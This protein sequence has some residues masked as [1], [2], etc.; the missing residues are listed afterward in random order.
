MTS[1][2]LL[3]LLKQNDLQSLQQ[4]SFKESYIFQL[5]IITVIFAGV[6]LAE[7]FMGL[8]KNNF[9]IIFDSLHNALHLVPLVFGLV[10]TY[11]ARK[12][13]DL[14]FSY[15]YSRL[16]IISSF[17]NCCFLIFFAV[18]LAFNAAHKI[19]ESFSEEPHHHFHSEASGNH[20][21]VA[22]QIMRLSIYF[23]G[24]YNLR[25]FSAD[26]Y[27]HSIEFKSGKLTM[28]HVKSSPKK[29][30]KKSDEASTNYA[31]SARYLNFYSIYLQ[32]VIGLL[33]TTCFLCV[34][35]F[36][37]LF[38]FHFEALITVGVLVY[39]A[40]KTKNVLLLSTDI[41]LQ[42]VP[43]SSR[44]I[45]ELLVQIENLKGVSNVESKY[46]AMS[47]NYSIIY[48]NLEIS[49]QAQKDE[50][51]ESAKN[52]LNEAFAEILIETTTVQI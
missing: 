20:L 18:F 11:I 36:P 49:Q 7:F 1:K 19:I 21:L 14:K 37:I 42:G 6:I 48:L 43:Q 38:S 46:W 40:F 32:M 50:I 2:S 5:L 52:I 39:T 41:L 27:Q 15:G 33:T 9:Q 12:P 51:E 13:K 17:T 8:L 44:R 45:E 22:F 4:I 16:E 25:Q 35:F 26:P 31:D 34:E 10:S 28:P 30:Y 3:S 23:A 47:P 24:R 29:Q